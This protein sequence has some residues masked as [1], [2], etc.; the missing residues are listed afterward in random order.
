MSKTKVPHKPK[1]VKEYCY[2]QECMDFYE[3][4]LSGAAAL[5]PQSEVRSA[6][7]LV[8]QPES[9]NGASKDE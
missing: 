2:C 1:V 7:A 9:P 6:G 8:A 5:S 3:Y 4:Y